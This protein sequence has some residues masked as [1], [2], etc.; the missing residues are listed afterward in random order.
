MNIFSKAH[1]TYL[2][3]TTA[4][5]WNRRNTHYG[6]FLPGNPKFMGPRDAVKLIRDGAVLATSGLAANQR[7]SIVYWAI[8][9]LFQETG[10]P[11]NLTV[12]GTGGQGG[13]GRAPGTAEELGLPGLCTRVV[14]G[15]IETFKKLLKLGEDGQA[16]LH[17]IPQGIVARLLEAQGRGED[18]L[19]TF[20]GV[21][22]FMDPRVGRG[23]PVTEKAADQ[24][25]AVEGGQLRYHMPKVDVAVFNAYAADREGNIY[26]THCPMKAEIREITLAAKRNGGIVIANVSR[27]VEKD[28]EA[29]YVSA[30]LVDAVVVYPKTEQ[31]CYVP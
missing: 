10:H 3:L 12:E 17:C 14:V 19:A 6:F 22:T 13:R 20:T 18:S 29:I 16:E 4:L 11:C 23:S 1:I 5:T 28:P 26:V 7:P 24:F 8:R 25:V 15:H 30:D 2:V 31:S 9:E 21:N 27:V